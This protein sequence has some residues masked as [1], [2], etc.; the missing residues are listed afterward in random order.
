MIFEKYDLFQKIE[1]NNNIVINPLNFKAV[2]TLQALKKTIKTILLD[3]NNSRMSININEKMKNDFILFKKSFEDN[4]NI[5]I[6]NKQIL[7]NEIEILEN[8][9]NFKDFKLDEI[10]ENIKKYFFVV[11]NL[12]KNIKG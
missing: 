8:Y 10:P 1:I 12:L 5:L 3:T 4:K 9:I 7:E 2:E 6:I 11:L